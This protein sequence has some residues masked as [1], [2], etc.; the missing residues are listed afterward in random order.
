MVRSVSVELTSRHIHWNSVANPGVYA[1]F[2]TPHFAGGM[3]LPASFPRVDH[4][5]LRAFSGLS[6]SA[7]TV[8]VFKMFCD[9]I[10][11]AD[12][13]ARTHLRKVFLG[14]WAHGLGL[15]LCVV[16]GYGS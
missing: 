14:C 3:L 12:L 11:P 10:P 1:I 13:E 16:C 8:E 15:E 9:D 4:D 6:F 7:V 2:I 5:T